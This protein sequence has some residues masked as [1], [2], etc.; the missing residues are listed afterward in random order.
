M[1]LSMP[2]GRE[3]HEDWGMEILVLENT[4]KSPMGA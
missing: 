4:Q 3:N 2:Q 1:G